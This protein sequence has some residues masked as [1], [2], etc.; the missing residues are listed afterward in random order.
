MN[1]KRRSNRSGAGWIAALTLCGALWSAAAPAQ[2]QSGKIGTVLGVPLSDLESFRLANSVRGVDSFG[3]AVQPNDVTVLHIS[4]D[5]GSPING[6]VATVSITRQGTGLKAWRVYFPQSAGGGISPLYQYIN[7][8][9]SFTN[10][11]VVGG[12]VQMDVRQPNTGDFTVEDARFMLIPIHRV[13]SLERENPG[14]QF[15]VVHAQQMASNFGPLGVQLIAVEESSA[16]R[17][18]LPSD[19]TSTLQA[20]N[21]NINVGPGN[22]AQVR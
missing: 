1:A 9:D 13:I 15:A 21:S 8:G 4:S 5:A 12:V 20:L 6:A 17:L 18:K 11:R 10:P 14:V 22:L 7:A 19:L 3:Q 2:A 16:A